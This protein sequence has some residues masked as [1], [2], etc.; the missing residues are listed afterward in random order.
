MYGRLTGLTAACLAAAWLWSAAGAA[1]PPCMVANPSFEL[2]GS[3]GAAFGGWNQFGPVGTSTRAVHGQRS[4]RVTGPNTGGWDVSGFWQTLSCAPGQRWTATVCVLNM[5]T[6]P[7]A[8]GS[9][10]IVNIEWRD[11]AGTL[12]SYESHAVADATT[13]VDTWQQVTV[14]S[15][16]APAGT[17][18]IHFVLGVLQGPGDPTPQVLFDLATCVNDGPPTLESQQW[19]DF[20]GGR[21]VTFAGRPWRVK[22]PGYYGPGPNLFDNG[23]GAVSVDSLGRMHMTIHR[24]GSSWY[25][26]EVA[27]VDALGYGDYVF[28][29]RG[30]LD[31]L[32]P[33]A[34]LGLFLW[35]Y[36][37]CYDT[38]FL[39]WNPYDEI[40][41]EFSRWGY[42]AN[43]LAQFV[44][45]PA[46]VPGNRFRFNPTFGDTERT[47]HAMRWLP[48]GVEFRSWRGGPDAESPS[49]TIATWTYTGGYLP[50][51]DA[52][53][54]HINLWQL[55]SPAVTQEVVLDGFTFR[56]A[57]PGGGCGA[58]A[59]DP[60]VS[61][62]PV[63]LEPLAPNPCV[64][65]TAI[66]YTLAVP[67]RVDLAVFD[68]AGR[69]I[70]RLPSGL[71]T[72]GRHVTR[73]DV[74]NDTGARVAAG[75]YVIALQ[76]GGR[77]ECRR[78]VVLP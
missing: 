32:D 48:Q 59:V 57:C 66:A 11:G 28:T 16:A 4:A 7:L 64:T 65:G 2:L 24:I 50:R 10:A 67:D 15:Q 74:R 44:A 60:P 62:A 58:L 13:S 29:T 54:V 27:L 23:T 51:P 25:S 3:G 8:G 61:R 38:A 77:T 20:S 45:Q 35:Q 39:W 53:R 70:R 69:R 42:P 52:P 18:S 43:A 6:A 40:D 75:V 78:V 31:L 9:Q 12:I 71:A 68:V 55:A 73:W 33:N 63:A 22:G 5:G 30:R 41:V 26:S 36:G 49:T 17:A 47:S 76:T 72:A 21:T 19:N 56:P 34:V 14:H 46:D 1:T 37:P